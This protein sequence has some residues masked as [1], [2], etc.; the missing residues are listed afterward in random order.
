MA[1]NKVGSLDLEAVTHPSIQR[2]LQNRLATRPGEKTEILDAAW[3]R[4][5]CLNAGADDV[6]FVEIEAEALSSQRAN[7]QTT[8]A[9]TRAVISIISRMNEDAVRSTARSVA[10]LEFH[11]V[12]EGINEIARHIVVELRKAGVRA[13]NPAAGFPMEMDRF[14]Q[15]IW[16]VGHKPV[17]VAAG[18]GK[19]GVHRNVIHPKFGNFILLD[20]ILIDTEISAYNRPIDYNPCFSCKL[21]VAACPVGA[22]GTDGHFNFSACFNHNYRDFMG[23]FG[24]WV[25]TIT[26]SKSSDDYRKEM[27]V[28]ETASI[29]QSLSFGPNYKAAYCMAV[30][31]AG[32]D[33][34]GQYLDN[35]KEYVERVV[36]PLQKKVETLYVVANTDAEKWAQARFPHKKIKLIGSGVKPATIKDFVDGLRLVFQPGKSEDVDLRYHF[37][38]YGAESSNVT[39]VIKDRRVQIADGHIGT[40]NLSIRAD[41]RL[42]LKFLSDRKFLPLGLL[43]GKIKMKGAIKHLLTFGEC[44]VT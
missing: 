3:L 9:Q 31:P 39:V 28:S 23:G 2:Y 13:V 16:T 29:W 42:W 12:T 33:V 32:D 35:K 41:S 36:K 11:H 27:S 22:I 7:I 10:N 1:E 20:S 17:A 34:I 5:V 8:F 37:E 30:C 43:T 44:F 19:M 25:E 24:N 14:P 6:G 21:C 4:Q 26:D 15:Q 38:F 18:M 40:A